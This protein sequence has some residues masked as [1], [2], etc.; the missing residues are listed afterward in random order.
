M[1]SKRLRVVVIRFKMT[2]KLNLLEIIFEF[3]KTIFRTIMSLKHA[4]NGNADRHSFIHYL[5]KK[6]FLS[7]P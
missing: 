2:I 3:L 7:R 1:V 5:I 4:C 6:L